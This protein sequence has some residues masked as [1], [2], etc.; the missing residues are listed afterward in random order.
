[1]NYQES[2]QFLYSQTASYQQQGATAYK[3]DLSNIRG[4]CEY[5]GNPQNAFSSIHIGGTNGKGSTTH[6]LTS[7]FIESG[8][9][10]G[11]YTSPHY[12]D[13]RERIRCNGEYIPKE[14][15]VEFLQL[16]QVAIKE[17]KP[18]FFELTFAMALWFFKE[19]NID[20]AAIEVGLGGR[21]DATNII[22]PILSIITN[23]AF[24]HQ[25]LLGNTLQEIAFEKA[26]IIKPNTPVI[27]GITQ[28]EI[29][30]V[31]KSKAREQN[32]ELHFADQ[33]LQTEGHAIEFSSMERKYLVRKNNREVFQ[34]NT[35]LLGQYQ[36]ENI[37]TAILAGLLLQ[38]ELKLTIEN[39][40]AG[41]QNVQQNSTI[42]GRFQVMQK[43][44]LVIIDSCHNYHGIQTFLQQISQLQFNQ[45]HIVYG[46]VSDKDVQNIEKLFPENTCLYLTQPQI[47]RKFPVNQLKNY[48]SPAKYTSIKS[49]LEVQS[50]LQDAKSKSKETD[51]IILFGSIFILSDLLQ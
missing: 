34:V 51:I 5:L 38:K 1:M 48:F 41:I 21:L 50:A 29:A 20:I 43:K 24:D 2:L 13:F 30:S 10:V 46:C 28:P 27:I 7:I 31:F 23:I 42:I 44:P 18:S 36:Q 19:E 33:A 15:V 3:K 11:T 6:I 17:V 25:Q 14:K 9:K 47:E 39:I 22:N 26:G 40:K 35:N 45:L 37:R 16:V 49:F 32:S 12:I 8:K 4:L